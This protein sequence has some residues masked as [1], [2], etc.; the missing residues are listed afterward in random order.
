M[1]AS[2]YIIDRK[3]IPLSFGQSIF[4]F[5]SYGQTDKDRWQQISKIVEPVVYNF[6]LFD[7][8]GI[9]DKLDVIGLTNEIFD[10]EKID[11]IQFSATEIKMKVNNASMDLLVKNK[12]ELEGRGNLRT[13]SLAIP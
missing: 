11:D 6:E 4:D 7:I 10:Q 5:L 2:N 9:Y 12:A 3:N 1:V 13:H 8:F